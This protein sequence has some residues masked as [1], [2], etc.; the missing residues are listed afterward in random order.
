MRNIGGEEGKRRRRKRRRGRKGRRK[1]KVEE[2]G[3]ESKEEGEEEGKE[4]GE[5]E[6]EE[7]EKSCQVSRAP[8]LTLPT[9]LR[10]VKV[11][12]LQWIQSTYLMNQ[13]PQAS[14]LYQQM[15]M[16]IFSDFLFP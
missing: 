9:C 16:C 6:E 3:E 7:E 8:Y 1:K 15:I 13:T 10:P 5:E 12:I 11:L 14:K 4:E 2:E